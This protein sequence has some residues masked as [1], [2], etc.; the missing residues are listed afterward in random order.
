MRRQCPACSVR[1]PPPQLQRPEDNASPPAVQKPKAPSAARCSMLRQPPAHAIMHSPSCQ[2][3]V[4]GAAGEL[5]LHW[6]KARE[7]GPW[8]TPPDQRCRRKAL[9]DWAVPLSCKLGRDQLIAAQDANTYA[10]LRTCM[11]AS[12]ESPNPTA[13]LTD[14][15]SSHTET[16]C[17][18]AGAAAATPFQRDGGALIRAAAPGAV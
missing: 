11:R 18:T 12:L 2:T 3:R 9:P 13:K 1:P 5:P 10:Q 17:R 4:Q 6:N 15:A 8:P 7:P 16:R 14:R